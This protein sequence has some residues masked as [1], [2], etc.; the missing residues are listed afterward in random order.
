MVS[1]DGA[2]GATAVSKLGLA[3]VAWT[4]ATQWEKRAFHKLPRLEHSVAARLTREFAATGAFE[5]NADDLDVKFLQRR[6]LSVESLVGAHLMHFKAMEAT[7]AA[8]RPRQSLQICAPCCVR[9][10]LRQYQIASQVILRSTQARKMRDC[11]AL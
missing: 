7:R 2:N 3:F 8:R 6:G 1:F 9:R 10:V 5:K 11:G 4:R